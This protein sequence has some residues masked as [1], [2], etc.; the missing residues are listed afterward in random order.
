MLHPLIMSVHSST[1]FTTSLSI[2]V[3]CG[4]RRIGRWPHEKRRFVGPLMR[5]CG[6]F[7]GERS[8]V[9]GEP[10]TCW[11]GGSQHG[12]GGHTAEE[13]RVVVSLKK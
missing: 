8:R 1:V 3:G 2:E 6:W 5:G 12:E 11:C 13:H 10:L 9:C 7:D 4:C